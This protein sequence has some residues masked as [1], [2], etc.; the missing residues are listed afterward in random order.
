MVAEERRAQADECAG[1]SADDWSAPTPCPRWRVR[2]LV[3]HLVQSP[4]FAT[5]VRSIVRHRFDV[6]EMVASSAIETARQHSDDELVELLRA[7]ATDR[8]TAPGVRPEG[9][10]L[11]QI[12]HGWDLRTATDRPVRDRPAERYRRALDYAVGAKSIFRGAARANGLRLVAT[13][14]DWSYG[15]GPLVTGPAELIVAGVL[16]RTRA[17]DALDGDGVPVLGS[18]C[19]PG[20][21][22]A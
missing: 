16:G 21:T 19:P 2:D 9:Q 4:S 15:S 5:L 20:P 22:S 14:V 7:H 11:D 12:V 18:R 8:W 3:G 6:D 13:D 1:Y 17:V 10:L